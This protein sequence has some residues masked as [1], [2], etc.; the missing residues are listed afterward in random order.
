MVKASVGLIF[1]GFVLENM[2]MVILLLPL[3]V[4]PEKLPRVKVL[5]E[6]KFV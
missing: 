6:V 3:I 1:G 4:L 5:P 2:V